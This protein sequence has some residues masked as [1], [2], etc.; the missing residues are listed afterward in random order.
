MDLHSGSQWRTAVPVQLCRSR[1]YGDVNDP[2]VRGGCGSEEAAVT[3]GA[4]KAALI[5]GWI[6]LDRRLGRLSWATAMLAA[7]LGYDL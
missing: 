4:V 7:V 2:E 6:Q 1:V 5:Q 3:A